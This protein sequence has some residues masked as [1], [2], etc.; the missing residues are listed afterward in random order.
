MN[1]ITYYLIFSAVIF[2]IGLSGLIIRKNIIVLFMSVELL[3]NSAN[4]SILAYSKQFGDSSFH[5]VCLFIM[6]VAAVEAALGLALVIL[7]FRHRG[8]ISSDKLNLLKG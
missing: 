3:L 7:I 5:A 2:I 1:E 8:T 4:I 6:A